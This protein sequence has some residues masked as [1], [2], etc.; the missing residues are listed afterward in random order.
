MRLSTN[1]H[2]Y[3]QNDEPRYFPRIA[4]IEVPKGLE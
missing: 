2:P 1:I 3:R 4:I